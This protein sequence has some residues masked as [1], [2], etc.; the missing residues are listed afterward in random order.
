M[1]FDFRLSCTTNL[2]IGMYSKWAAEV[3]FPEGCVLI[4]SLTILNLVW[5]SWALFCDVWRRK[6]HAFLATMIG[7]GNDV[8]F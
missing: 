1:I 5:Y 2:C 8:E 7:S 3:F 6:A 4:L